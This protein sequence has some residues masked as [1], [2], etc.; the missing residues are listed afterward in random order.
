MV[1]KWLNSKL[2]DTGNYF[3]LVLL[4]IGDQIILVLLLIIIM[5]IFAM[6]DIESHPNLSNIRWA[7]FGAIGSILTTILLLEPN[8]RFRLEKRYQNTIQTVKNNIR[9]FLMF[10]FIH[11]RAML[12]LELRENDKIAANTNSYNEITNKVFELLKKELGYKIEDYNELLDTYLLREIWSLFSS[13]IKKIMRLID[14]LPDDIKIK[15][16]KYQYDSLLIDCKDIESLLKEDFVPLPLILLFTQKINK[17]RSNL[18]KIG[19]LKF[20][21]N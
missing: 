3:K 2:K 20:H 21:E 17:L 11:F 7:I 8:N 6:L 10:Y 4:N 15:E 13:E 12:N 18:E 19:Y 14:I 1:K 5:A 9:F 16:Y